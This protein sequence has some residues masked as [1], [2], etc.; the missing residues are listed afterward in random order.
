MTV[1]L[2]IARISRAHGLRGEVVV[3]P[4]SDQVDRFVVGARYDTR[5]GPMVIS[6]VR[7]FQHRWLVCFEGCT[8]R[9]QAEALAGTVLL[10]EPRDGEGELFVH[11]LIGR[12]VVDQH[13]TNHGPV[14]AVEAN[15][16]ADLLVL[17]NGALVP[18]NFMVALNGDLI[19]VD[20]PAGLLD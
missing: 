18:L 17:T 7:P 6:A 9:E 15:P 12:Q 2:E 10:A 5:R 3:V 14:T 20:V 13:G 1:L 11:E 16:A 19:E 4:I 8:T